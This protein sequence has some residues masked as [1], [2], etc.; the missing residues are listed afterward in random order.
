MNVKM[1]LAVLVVLALFIVASAPS[2]I[3]APIGGCPDGFNLH[4]M[5]DHNH[6]GNGDHSHKHVGNDKDLNGDGYICGKHVGKGGNVHVHIDNN[7]PLDES[8]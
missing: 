7:I 3:A 6:G 1:L 5:A 2:A 8:E 4:S